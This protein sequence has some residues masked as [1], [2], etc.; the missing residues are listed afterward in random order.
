MDKQGRTRKVKR[1]SVFNALFKVSKAGRI[2]DSK[3][4]ENRGITV[5]FID[6]NEVISGDEEFIAIYKPRR[7]P[8]II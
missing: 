5:R 6:N 1:R 3:Y 8:I 2:G 7:I 4:L